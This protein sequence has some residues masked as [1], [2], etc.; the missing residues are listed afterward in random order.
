MYS[1]IKSKRNVI[2]ELYTLMNLSVNCSKTIYKII[3]VIKKVILYLL[4][5]Q[6]MYLKMKK[7]PFEKE[8]RK[9]FL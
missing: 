7:I 3:F 6:N 1:S 2:S 8:K 5:L 4:V 9:L